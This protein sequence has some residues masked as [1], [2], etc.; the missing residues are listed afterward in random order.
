MTIRK[1]QLRKEEKPRIN[2]IKPNSPEL[3]ELIS[4]AV[5]EM[6]LPL[7]AKIR[8]V[9][10]KEFIFCSDFLQLLM[11]TSEPESVPILVATELDNSL[12]NVMS[13]G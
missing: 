7:L 12:Y 13:G 6:D 5:N 3:R 9:K 10:N 1:Q 4:K 11:A 8:A 2:L